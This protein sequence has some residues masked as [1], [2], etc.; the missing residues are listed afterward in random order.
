MPEDATHAH[1]GALSQYLKPA[2]EATPHDVKCIIG[3]CYVGVS[4]AARRLGD[5][6]S[7]GQQAQSAVDAALE[8]RCP[9]LEAS[10]QA[11]LGMATFH[12]DRCATS[13]KPA[14]TCTSTVPR[15][16]EYTDA[17]QSSAL[18]TPVVTEARE[19]RSAS[20]PIFK[21]NLTLRMRNLM[22]ELK[23]GSRPPCAAITEV[24]PAVVNLSNA[25]AAVNGR[26]AAA[27]EPAH[28]LAF[29][30]FL[31]TKTAQQLLMLVHNSAEG[32]GGDEGAPLEYDTGL[33][34]MLGAPQG[35]QTGGAQAGG[36][37][38]LHIADEGAAPGDGG[39][40]DVQVRLCQ[41]GP[42]VRQFDSTLG[43]C[44]ARRR[45]CAVLECRPFV[46][47]AQI[48]APVLADTG[49][50]ASAHRLHAQ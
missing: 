4:Y 47:H 49:V 1:A 19:C 2:S 23:A 30:P 50:A 12:T 45:Y 34:E 31:D 20:V 3:E 38:A 16:L 10:A 18:S 43:S 26:G 21:R 35:D 13:L 25:Q 15:L 40:E 11:A 42:A 8:I 44:V 37:G 5:V 28:A 6:E 39:E 14:S 27:R 9:L 24:I 46:L 29:L 32:A 36:G 41:P 48:R 17:S 33:R 22:R 7:A